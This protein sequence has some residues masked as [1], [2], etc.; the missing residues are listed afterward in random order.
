MERSC[1]AQLIA[2]A[3]GEPI[4]I[5][6]TEAREVASVTGTSD[7]GWFNFQPLHQKILALEPDLLD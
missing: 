6:E 4:L 1:Q 3:A 2:M 5:G 7:F